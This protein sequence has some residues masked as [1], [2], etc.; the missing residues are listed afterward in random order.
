MGSSFRCSRWSGVGA[1]CTIPRAAVARADVLPAGT[2]E[3]WPDASHLLSAEFPQRLAERL[4]EW[5]ES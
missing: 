5:W 2:V 3:L 1:A 4:D